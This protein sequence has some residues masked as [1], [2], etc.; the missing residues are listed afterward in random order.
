MSK[1]LDFVA[2]VKVELSK[3][4]A[5]IE[6]PSLGSEVRLSPRIAW[7]LAEVRFEVGRSQLSKTVE[8]PVNGLDTYVFAASIHASNLESALMIRSA[9][10]S[11][12]IR[13]SGGTVKVGPAEVTLQS[14]TARGVSIDMTVSVTVPAQ[15]V[16]ELGLMT[17]VA[18]QDP[19]IDYEHKTRVRTVFRIDGSDVG[20]PD[21][22]MSPA[23]TS[24]FT[25]QDETGGAPCGTT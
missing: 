3:A 24:E 9:L 1:A 22:T 14:G 4:V 6:A 2:A 21:G 17:F 12:A 11:A 7:G 10:V 15:N 25:D 23:V 19:D 5:W 8:Y 18:G 13:A 16:S 20:T